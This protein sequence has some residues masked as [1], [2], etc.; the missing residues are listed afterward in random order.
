VQDVESVILRDGI[1]GW[2]RAGEEYTR[3]MDGFDVAVWADRRE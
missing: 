3:L 1:K 2:V